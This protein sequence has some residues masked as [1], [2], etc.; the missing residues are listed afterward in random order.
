MGTLP[1]KKNHMVLILGPHTNSEDY[2]RLLAISDLTQFEISFSY[3]RNQVSWFLHAMLKLAGGKP[4]SS[5]EN[6]PISPRKS[7]ALLLNHQGENWTELPHYESL[8]TEKTPL[9][10]VGIDHH[11][12]LIKFHNPFHLSGYQSRDES[13]IRGYFAN[14]FSYADPKSFKR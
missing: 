7:T 6:Q 13:F 4:I 8:Y 11:R 5:Q 2:F 3:K 9:V 1:K 12:K 14:F 10:L